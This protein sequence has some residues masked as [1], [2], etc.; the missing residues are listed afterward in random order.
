[1]EEKEII[2]VYYIYLFPESNWRSIVSQQLIRLKSFKILE[3]AKLYVVICDCFNLIE[4]AQIL[5]GNLVPEADISVSFNNQFEYPGIKLVYDLAIEY[6]H[7]A[8]I[9]LHAKGVSHNLHTR[10]NLEVTLFEL[11]F[12]DW[13]QHI[14]RLKS[15][16]ASKIGLFPAKLHEN[17]SVEG[18][19]QGWVW[20]NYWYATGSY[21]STCPAPQI[22]RDRYY[23]EG[24]LGDNGYGNRRQSTECYSIYQIP[25]Y[26]KIY[27]L[28]E[29]ADYFLNK[30]TQ[31][32]MGSSILKKLIYSPLLAT[33]YRAVTTSIT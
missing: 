22:D 10:S 24:W 7:K 8:F 23:Y 32:R 25:G 1:M 27:F 18:A 5:V 28:P 13:H 33:L 11:T 9:Y 2:I 14:M 20:F 26:K 6:P 3:A 4:E 16:K 12:K 15:G 17:T 21:L 19:R 30:A 29:E 31:R